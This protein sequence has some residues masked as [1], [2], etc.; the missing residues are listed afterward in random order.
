MK[1]S[2]NDDASFK[3]Q[4]AKSEESSG[5]CWSLGQERGPAPSIILPLLCPPKT[6]GEYCH[7]LYDVALIIRVVSAV[8]SVKYAC[9]A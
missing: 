5:V 6:R 2:K 1:Q 4:N 9:A 7:V 8:V 3:I